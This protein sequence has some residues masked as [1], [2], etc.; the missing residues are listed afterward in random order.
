MSHL[1]PHSSALS[2]YGISSVSGAVSLHLSSPS[3]GGSGPRD[4]ELLCVSFPH[5]HSCA[6]TMTSAV[7]GPGQLLQRERAQRKGRRRNKCVLARLA[8]YCITLGLGKNKLLFKL[9][10][11]F[12]TPSS[13]SAGSSS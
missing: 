13:A 4:A 7:L 5:L 8:F 2:C 1:Q 11:L 3:P 9:A 10:I 6:W 12:P